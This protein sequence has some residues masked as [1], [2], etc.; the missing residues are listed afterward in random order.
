MHI[1]IY[2]KVV[3]ILNISRLE[4]K[5]SCQQFSKNVWLPKFETNI[6]K[7]SQQGNLLFTAQ[8][9]E[10]PWGSKSSSQLHSY[11]ICWGHQVQSFDN[12]HVAENESVHM[13]P[14]RIISDKVSILKDLRF[15]DYT[16][17]STRPFDAGSNPRQHRWTFAPRA[18]N[19]RRWPNR[20]AK[21]QNC[22]LP[23]TRHWRR[24]ALQSVRFGLTL[25]LLGR[26]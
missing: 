23:W 24:D 1:Y 21:L 18:P 19:C 17:F 4:T 3:T 20:C 7:R 12:G 14:F 9:L 8:H 2:I 25:K 13:A 22:A 26:S 11:P 15:A 10:D 5:K 16:S 6:P